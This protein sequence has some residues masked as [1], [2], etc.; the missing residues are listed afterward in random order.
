MN[1]LFIYAL[2][3]NSSLLLFYL[4]YLV[5]YR[6]DTFLKIRRTYL[7]TAILFS[8]LYPLLQFG[9]W[10]Q[11]QKTVQVFATAINLDEIVVVSKKAAPVVFSTENILLSIYVL[12]AFSLLFKIILQTISIIFKS[13]KGDKITIDGVEVIHLNEN[14]TPFSFFNFIFLNKDQHSNVELPEIITH[15]LSHVRQRHSYDVVLSEILT[16]LCWFN[17]AAWLLK[18]EIKQNLEFLA[19][20]QVIIS[21][22]ETKKYQ[23][24]LL[25][26]SCN[27]V[28]N[29]LINQFNISPIKKRITMMNKPKTS[30]KGLI[31]YSLIVPIAFT[32]LVVSNAQHVSAMLQKKSKNVSASVQSVQKNSATKN[33][34]SAT[35]VKMQ[36]GSIVYEVTDDSPMFPG[37]DKAL[38]NYL[39]E[40]IKYPE[41]AR[42]NKIQGYATVGFIIDEKGKVID[43]QVINT[44]NPMLVKEALRVVAS[45]PNWIPGKV[46]G[47]NVKCK[48][49]IPIKFQLDEKG[50]SEQVN[51]DINTDEIFETVD[52]PPSFPGGENGLIRYLSQNIKYPVI[53]QESGAMGKVIVKFIINQEGKVEGA[54]IAKTEMKELKPKI[55]VTGYGKND[56]KENV[57]GNQTKATS[58][59]AQKA[60][61]NEAVRIV[62]SMPL[63]TPGKNKGQ[64]VNVIYYLPINFMLQ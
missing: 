4:F 33:K 12:I 29:Q 57:N 14:I 21:G 25:N 37:G 61:E 10:F 13:H 46:K 38:F 43:P 9:E 30:G 3:V 5:M 48:F 26:I 1:Q 36:D 6:R 40:N 63:W 59:L 19:D 39:N 20:N 22:F 45:M 32:M 28:D 17:P 2:K 8:F 64:S 31:K 24:L 56:N 11:Q 7:L 51:K 53:A 52:T 62:N 49:F 41:E 35:P 16:A 23:Y 34:V 58:E 42:N 18:K 44:V 27:Y 15:E 54:T 55:T 60:L 50:F 47:K